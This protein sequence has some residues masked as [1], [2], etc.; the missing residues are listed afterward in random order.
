MELVNGK[1]LE[2][3]VKQGLVWVRKAAEQ[4]IAKA[5]LEIGKAHISDELTKKN[6]E[7]AYYW[8]SLAKDK[9]PEAKNA[10]SHISI[11]IKPDEML[12]ALERVAK[13]KE[14]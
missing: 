7:E 8:F 13:S 2:K 14:K 5:Q 10:L 9:I 3:D 1:K 6:L 11:E 12:R 4:G